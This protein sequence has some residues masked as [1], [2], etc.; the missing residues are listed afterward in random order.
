MEDLNNDPFTSYPDSAIALHRKNM[1]A[2]ASL[3]ESIHQK[4]VNFKPASK[5]VFLDH[6]EAD[7]EYGGTFLYQQKGD[8]TYSK[9]QIDSFWERPFR[10]F[11]NPPQTKSL[12]DHAGAFITASLKQAVDENI[13]FTQSYTD[14]RSYFLFLMGVGL[15]P[16]LDRLIEQTSCRVLILAEPNLDFLYH[17]TFVYDWANLFR[18]VTETRELDI[19]FITSPDPMVIGATHKEIVRTTNPAGWDGAVFFIHYPSSV[20]NKALDLFGKTFLPT[21]LLGLGFFEDELHMVSQTYANLRSRN[22]KLTYESTRP[23]DV[24]VF[25]VGN[26]PSLDMQIEVIRENQDK[27]IVIACGSALRPLA[28]NGIKADFV[29]ILER[30]P[31]QRI[32]IE[33][34]LEHQSLE[35]VCLIAST[36]VMPDIPDFFGDSLFYFRTGLSS[37]PLFCQDSTH[38]LPLAD[39]MAANATINFAINVGFKEFYLF[40]VDMGSK[41]EGADHSSAYVHPPNRK[42]GQ[43]MNHKIP[44]NFGGSVFTE[45]VY[46]WSK[47]AMEIAIRLAGKTRRFFNVSDGA[48]I[49]GSLP[50]HFSTLKLQPIKTDKNLIVQS[51]KADCPIYPAALAEQIWQQA[52]LLQTVPQLCDGLIRTIQ[53]SPSLHSPEFQESI[54]G[55][56]P[57]NNNDAA[58]PMIFRGTMVL[59]MASC[60]FYLNRIKDRSKQEK[61]EALFKRELV[62]LVQTM[63]KEALEAFTL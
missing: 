37:A 18:K 11:Q 10:S 7:V 63:E 39:P 48:K 5:L 51:I 40:G 16:H 41:I 47:E 9:K 30:G 45:E 28:E 27:A 60:H 53:E 14:K 42:P 22:A 20:L 24:P 36:T 17:S 61:L 35:D 3:Q 54:M 56:L 49:N 19:R 13:E 58:L 46:I 6:G 62:S 2:F 1:E 55:I 32:Y 8:K 43:D 34:A 15:A 52:N 23:I 31:R 25:L 4:L 12:D 33:K 44:G 26:G 59:A 50:R 21:T 38:T 57:P 29:T